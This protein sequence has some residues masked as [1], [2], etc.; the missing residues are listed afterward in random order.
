MKNCVGPICSV[1]Q[2]VSYIPFLLACEPESNAWIIRK[3][4]F[5][6]L[7]EKCAAM[8]VNKSHGD[9]D[10]ERLVCQRMIEPMSN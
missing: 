1:G 4:V 9:I 6:S 5:Y 2:A 10:A 8:G 7:C 3:D